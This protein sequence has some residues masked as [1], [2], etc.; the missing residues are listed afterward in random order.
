MALRE[1]SRLKDHASCRLSSLK[2]PW[3]ITNLAFFGRLL[4]SLPVSLFFWGRVSAS[5]L[6]IISLGMVPT[7]LRSVSSEQIWACC[8]IQPQRERHMTAIPVLVV[9]GDLYLEGEN[10]NQVPQDFNQRSCHH[11]L[12]RRPTAEAA[13]TRIDAPRHIPV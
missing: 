11:R 12:A 6:C 1:F 9:S 13:V 5:P 3:W 2:L 7:T 10:P 4:G 8:C